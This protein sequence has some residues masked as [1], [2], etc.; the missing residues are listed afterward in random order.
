MSLQYNIG[1]D[2]DQMRRD[3]D[4]VKDLF[5]KM[6][7]KAQIEANRMDNIFNKASGAIAGY[8]SARMLAGFVKEVANVRG[9]FESLEISFSTMLGS[10][11]KA[12]QL[13]KQMV[14][15][16]AKTPFT[17]QQVADGAKQLL[18][19]QV[20]QEDVNGTLIKLGNI[21]A[22]LGVPLE[23]LIMV[24]GQV[25]AKGRLMGDDLKQFTEAGVP[26]VHELAKQMGI[27]DSEVQ[28]LVSSGKVGFSDVDQV[29]RN[30][31]NSGG[32]FYNLMAEQSKSLTGQIS[33]LEDAWSRMM[34]SIGE[35]S[36]G[37][38]SGAVQSAQYLV[39]NYETVGK[40]IAGL[41][42]T[43]GAYK[44][45]VITFNAAQAV[46]ISLSNG[47]TIA[48]LA[49]FNALVLVEKA[50]SMLNKTM[51]SNPYVLAA[52]A[53]AAL[54]AGIA[55][56]I[57]STQKQTQAEISLQNI[58]KKTTDQYDEQKVK[59]DS[60]IS[61]LNNEK[62]A[63]QNRKKAL[64]D[65][66]QIVPDYHASLTQEGK[67]INSNT[68]AI[69]DYLAAFEKQ[70]KFQAA[71]DELVELYKKKRQQEKNVNA[72][73]A[74]A[75]KA[76]ASAST[77]IIGES[78]FGNAG[79]G[80]MAGQARAYANTAKEELNGTIDAIKAINNEI[81]ASSTDT[82]KKAA[83]VS[84]KNKAFWEKQKKD[85]EASRDAMDISLK[86]NSDWNKY[87][88]LIEQADK[89]LKNWSDSKKNNSSKMAQAEYD[90]ATKLANAKA[91]EVLE[92]RQREI[93]GQKS[94]IELKE[95]GYQK[96]KELIDINH[97]QRLL[98]IDKQ[99][100]EL[101]QKQQES[102]KL[103][104]EQSGKK[105]K[106]KASNSLNSANQSAINSM[107][108][109]ES[110]QYAGQTK[111]LLNEISKEYQSFDEKRREIDKRYSEDTKFIYE[112][113]TGDELITR[114]NEVNTKRKEAIQSIDRDEADSILRTSRLFVELF[115][116]ASGKSVDS[117][118]MIAD[119]AEE[120]F[121]YLRTTSAEN[122]TPKF[123]FTK[124]QLLSIKN[125]KDEMYAIQQQITSLNDQ[126]NGMETGFS[127]VST[128]F[129]DIFSGLSQNKA[130]KAKVAEGEKNKASGI[131]SLVGLGN[132]QTEIGNKDQIDGITKYQKGL[133]S[134]QESFQTVSGYA[135]G[136]IGLLNAMSSEEGD[137]F[138]S[139]AKSIGAVMDIAD[140]TLK[141]FQQGGIVGGVFA[142]AT[143][144]L[145][146]VFEAEK[147]H[148]QALK[149]LQQEKTAQQKEYNDL[150]IEQNKL[151]S[152]AETI[153]GVDGYQKAIGYAQQLKEYSNKLYSEKITSSVPSSGIFAAIYK[154]M[155]IQAKQYD[156][157][158][159][160][161]AGAQVQTGTKKTGLFGWGGEKAIYSNLL[162]TYPELIDANGKLNQSLAKSILNNNTLTES[163]KTAL[164]SALDYSEKY[165]EALANMKNYLESV[166]GSLGSDMM[167]AITSNLG[168]T[169]NALDDFAN[170]AAGTIETLMENIAY[171]MFFAD[172]FK[173]LSDDVMAIQKDT[174]LTPEQMA[175]QQEALL[176]E[177]YKNIGSQV[178]A[179][180]SFLKDS[181]AAAAASGFDLWNTTRSASEKGFASM[182]QDS[183][184]ELNGRFTAI[185]GHTYKI[186]ESIKIL[187]QNSA[188]AL[189][190]LS[191]IDTNTGRL[192]SMQSDMK[193]VKS[194]IET[195]TLKGVKIQ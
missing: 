99:S 145:T 29:I 110:M 141:G 37:V 148:Q 92:Q 30:L 169:Q 139:A 24:Y 116:D 109:G 182:S 65:I 135:S 97:K 131:D 8:F 127:K 57:S 23:R 102:E 32:M 11:E 67:L 147:A 165:D 192:E 31:T 3:A 15:T 125:G 59:L 132:K 114:I 117:I 56:Y 49:H 36:Q 33:N 162:K 104:W 101:L 177:F 26:M 128:A 106:F 14:D 85:A 142:F 75:A 103:L 134:L 63:L 84:V 90:A 72:K 186:T 191:N 129:K 43:Y 21:S 188:Q 146:K 176:A 10:K 160:S 70:V 20:A 190:H 118:R 91:K 88:K 28:K 170:S 161:L 86:G 195:I 93:D 181:Q 9:E 180:N 54:V 76:E 52:T 80:L 163:S 89:E 149:K 81:M 111:N 40:I 46:G 79:R 155:G 178:D 175:A 78:G 136:A 133:Q 113:F 66:K 187:Q 74:S 16:A 164:Q 153:F 124:E 58:K 157:I 119:R 39:D 22:G 7:D 184:D 115:D 69:D 151:L 166:F 98:D 150:L 34:N 42:V 121:D 179:A 77:T 27:A 159:A 194:G 185:Q 45:A 17:L 18:A 25:K 138:A 100:Q 13:M 105:G 1:M 189:V 82:L 50:Q 123:G 94:I 60:L 152:N 47:W 183:A 95:D 96:E 137:G 144:T 173:K 107:V 87:T 71:Q 2:L 6:T 158:V 41:V 68:K 171:S 112:N 38:M 126:A 5:A 35:S 108:S 167:E 61:V 122:I 55:I 64:D 48:E 172:K 120:L 174:G 53:L 168:N 51:L 154:N 83:E 4:Q 19:Y 130:G 62:I 73:E 140:N 193:S 44:A 143:S 156:G 12:N